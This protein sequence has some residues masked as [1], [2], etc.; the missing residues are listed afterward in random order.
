MSLQQDRMDTQITDMV[1][2][3]LRIATVSD[4]PPTQQP[5]PDAQQDG[6]NEDDDASSTQLAHRHDR[7]DAVTCGD[8]EPAQ[9]DN[10]DEAADDDPP[11]PAS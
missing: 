7:E 1:L 6:D 10:K 4:L 9:K 3:L 2:S 11:C 8:G 5:A